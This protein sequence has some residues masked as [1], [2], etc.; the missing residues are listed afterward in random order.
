MVDRVERLSRDVFDHRAHGAI[1]VGHISRQH[2][3]LLEA[4]GDRLFDAAVA[5]LDDVAVA[6]IGFGGND[7]RLDDAD[8]LY[9]CQQQRIRLRG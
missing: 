3:D 7:R 1:V 6:A 2:L 9:R 5:G 4:G 8:S